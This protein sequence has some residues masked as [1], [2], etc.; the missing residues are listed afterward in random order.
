MKAKIMITTCIMAIVL[1]ACGSQSKKLD[2]VNREKNEPVQ[3]QASLSA[4]D[5]IEPVEEENDYTR[6]KALM[7][8]YEVNLVKAI[9]ENDFSL[10]EPYLLEESPLYLSQKELVANLSERGIL[11][12]YHSHEVGYVYPE[13]DESYRVEVV[14]T[15]KISYPEQGEVIK[16]FQW[17]YTVKNHND[18][19]KLSDIQEWSSFEE[20]LLQRQGRAKPD[21]YYAWE[22]LTLFET[23][24]V[25]TLN[26]GESGL[27]KL[28]KDQKVIAD[29]QALIAKLKEK[30]TE[31]QLIETNYEELGSGL[32]LIAKPQITLKYR[33]KQGASKEI[34]LVLTMEVEEYYTGNSIVYGGYAKISELKDFKIN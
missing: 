31:F 5:E 29:Y 24:L 15:I 19:M 25:H 13:D 2:G 23:D 16:D 30:G 27:E 6:I 21:G 17:I 1:T 10:V 32:P 18:T 28:L 4:E 11:E 8:G 14:E 9:N 26:G 12:E 3:N 20:D 7:E 22:A 34:K 33:D